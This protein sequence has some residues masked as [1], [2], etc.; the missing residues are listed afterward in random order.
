MKRLLR[1]WLPAAA[2]ESRPGDWRALRLIPPDQPLPYSWVLTGR[3]AVGPMPAG[4]AHWRQL[5]AAGLQAR[6]SCCYPEEEG[7]V[8]TPPHW[9]SDRLPLPDHRSQEAL[10][11][12]RLAAALERAQ[13]L[14]QDSA[15]LYLHCLAGVERSPLLAVG[16]TARERDLSLFEA[17]DWVRRC[18]PAAQPLVAHLE[19]LERLLTVPR[20]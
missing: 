10:D 2:G 1:R 17:L 20:S 3:L 19:V 7:P 5:E 16:L 15:P 14:L 8:P 18:H 4:A 11:P 9:R 13:G 6:F 12:A